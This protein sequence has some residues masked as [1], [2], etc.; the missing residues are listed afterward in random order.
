V[1]D[2]GRTRLNPQVNPVVAIIT[3]GPVTGTLR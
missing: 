1:I 2:H 3:R